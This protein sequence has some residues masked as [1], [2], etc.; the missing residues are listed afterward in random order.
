M[1][2]TTKNLTD[3]QI[4]KLRTAAGQ[5]GDFVQV[6]ICDLAID[7]GSLSVDDYTTID[8]SDWRKRDLSHMTQQE[9]YLACADAIAD[10]E[11]R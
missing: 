9:A 11:A 1:T 10:A 4:S 7:G 3:T 6:A 5:A 2:T 8:P